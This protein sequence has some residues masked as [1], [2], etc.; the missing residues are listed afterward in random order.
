MLHT[1]SQVLGHPNAVSSF[2]SLLPQEGCLIAGRA[3]GCKTEM[4][5]WQ[6]DM[7]QD[8]TRHYIPAL[9]TSGIPSSWE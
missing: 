4:R 7:E 2:T 9:P 6:L 5:P 8:G 3:Q 1:L